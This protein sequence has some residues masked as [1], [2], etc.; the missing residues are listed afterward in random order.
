MHFRMKGKATMSEPGDTRDR[1]LAE[2]YLEEME[3]RFWQYIDDEIAQTGKTEQ[4][5]LDSIKVPGYTG[6]KARTRRHG[7]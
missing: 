3:S 1:K 7:A 6:L 2:G 5:I 4:E